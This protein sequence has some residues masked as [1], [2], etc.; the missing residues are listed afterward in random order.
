MSTYKNC[1]NGCC[2]YETRPYSRCEFTPRNKHKAGVFIFDKNLNKILLVQSRGNLWGSPKGSIEPNESIIECALR[3]V[4]EETGISI[5]HSPAYSLTPEPGS[6]SDSNKF[7]FNDSHYFYCDLNQCSISLDS[8]MISNDINDAS[9]I[10]WFSIPCLIDLIK[11]D[12]IFI[13]F[14]CKLLLEYF[15]KI[16]I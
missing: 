13:N 8:P 12:K 7:I 14:H 3:E 4:F 2:T 9:G 15:L 1:K 11:S 6:I 10:G 16:D 5:I